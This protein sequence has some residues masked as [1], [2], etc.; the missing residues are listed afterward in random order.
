MWNGVTFACAVSGVFLP[1]A[2]CFGAHVWL[3][4]RG[5]WPVR[6]GKAV[7]GIAVA[8]VAT[9]ALD[10]AILTVLGIDVD[11]P[12]FSRP[13]LTMLGRVSSCLP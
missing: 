11:S 10:L 1:P 5:A 3:T 9:V 2:A 7:L 4:R 13:S 8:L 12:L 6:L